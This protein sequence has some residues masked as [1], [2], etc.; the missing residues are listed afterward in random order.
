MIENELQFQVTVERVRKLRLQAE[1]EANEAA[2]TPETRLEMSQDTD[3]L[4]HSIEREIF[5]YL[6]EK[7]GLDWDS[8]Y[9]KASSVR[10]PALAA[11]ED[12]GE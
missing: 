6:A 8:V 9:D 10:P 12:P 5:Q 11:R 3:A 2:W 4:R 1:A 7:Y